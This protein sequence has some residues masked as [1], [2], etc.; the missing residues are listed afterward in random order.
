M[1]FTIVHDGKGT[2]ATH[3]AS[4]SSS[5]ISLPSELEAARQQST[6]HRRPFILRLIFGQNRA[7]RANHALVIVYLVTK[8]L[9][10]RSF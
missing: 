6:V 10:N 8:Y 4:L 9:E 1:C 2:L 7:F 5:R 3:V